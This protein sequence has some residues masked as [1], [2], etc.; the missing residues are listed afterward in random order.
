M[1]EPTFTRGIKELLLRQA[2][3]TEFD[4]EHGDLAVLEIHE[5]TEKFCYFYDTTARRLI[6]S[7]VLK[8][9]PQ[10]DILCDVVLIKKGARYTPRLTL[11]RKDKTKGPKDTLTEEELVAEG[12]ILLIKGRV[13]LGDCHESFWKLIDF[14]RTCQ[15]IELPAHAFRVADAVLVTAFE[16]HDKASVLDAVKTYLGGNLT[17][18]DVR[19]LVDRR[20]TLDMFR[21]LLDEP[22]FVESHRQEIEANGV[23]GVWQSFFESN[24]WV[25]GYGLQLVACE[26]YDDE[27]LERMSTG[28]NVF[29]G[30]GKRS[31]AVMRTKGFIQTLL[32]GEI[33]K[34]TTALLT[35]V[36]YRKPDVYQVSPELSGAVSQVHKT[37]H[38][39]VKKLEDLHRQSNPSGGFAFEVST[40]RPR[41]VVIIGS[42]AELADDGEINVEKMTSFELWRKAQLGVEI[43]TFDELYERTRFIVESHEAQVPSENPD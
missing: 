18:A 36:P 8:D 27:K 7:F 37:A 28:A 12:R 16:G 15:A 3:E 34:H 6:K 38:K 10:V 20:R 33:K 39:A 4:V 13:D 31:D 11:W 24:P 29:T 32:F 26:R 1:T 23:E 19:M 14:L 35:A 21:R 40:I 42:L 41:Q 5:A 43:L 2:R 25:F 17:E 9:G 30:G 22:D